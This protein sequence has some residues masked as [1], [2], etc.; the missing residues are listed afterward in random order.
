M[1]KL[2]IL[3]LITTLLFG[4]ESIEIDNEEYS[5]PVDL[6][7]ECYEKHGTDNVA[8]IG[9]A[10]TIIGKLDDSE[11]QE[12]EEA[13]VGCRPVQINKVEKEEEKGDTRSLPIKMLCKCYN[14][15]GVEDV[16]CKGMLKTMTSK[17]N[18]TEKK[19]FKE[20]VKACQS[21]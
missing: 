12:F 2:L 21:E 7:C 16:V 14:E 3:G 1:N 18:D 8:C 17:L 20:A 13:I 5:D 9:M 4:C 6:V 15:S 19:E 11:K 10:K